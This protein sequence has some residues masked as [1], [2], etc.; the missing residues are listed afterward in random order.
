[1]LEGGQ[2]D[3]R[4]AAD[5]IGLPGRLAQSQRVD[6]AFLGDD[7]DTPERSPQVLQLHEAAGQRLDRKALDV[8]ELGRG[9]RGRRRRA[10]RVVPGVN[11][12]HCGH[13]VAPVGLLESR[14]DS[15]CPPVG[16]DQEKK[17]PFVRRELVRRDPLQRRSRSQRQSVDA[18]LADALLQS[19]QMVGLNCHVALFRLPV[20]M[21]SDPINEAMRAPSARLDHPRPPGNMRAMELSIDKSYDTLRDE[22]R[23]FLE[24]H[25]DLAVAAGVGARDAEQSAAWQ[26]ALV[27]GGWVGRTIPRDYGGFGAQPDL[28]EAIVIEEEFE[29]AGVSLGMQNQGIS[30]LVPTLLEYGNEEQKRQHIGTTLRAETIWCQGYSEPGSGSD[31]ASL[32]TRGELRGDE[33]VINGQKIWTSTAHLADMMFALV[34]TEPDAGKHGGISYILLSMDTPGIEVR[35]L[36]TMTGESSFNEVFFTDVRVPRQNLVGNPGQGWEIATYLLRH[37]RAMLGRTNQ[38]E[39]FLSSCVDV[40]RETGLIQDP[41]YRDRLVTLQGRALAMK[42]HSLRLLTNTLKKR[43]SGVSSLI[44]KLNGCQL[45]Y[46]VCALAIDAMNERGIL[47]AGSRRVRDDGAWQNNYMYALGLI[48]GGGTAQIQKNIIS[49]VGLGMPREPKPAHAPTA[50]GA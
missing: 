15:A 29:R 16:R 44:V 25:R 26:K 27:E 2:G 30:M 32:Q 9:F 39:S 17:Q 36:K 35:P 5:G 28:L 46:D 22:V 20:S 18:A 41:V 33:Y 42:Y 49:E 7:L 40:L 45:N 1:M 23:S 4:R 13:G 31:L 6:D 50:K 19:F 47:K 14:N 37:E 34:R 21:S 43:G 3:R 38:T 48:I 11:R 12:G 10:V 24:S 8:A